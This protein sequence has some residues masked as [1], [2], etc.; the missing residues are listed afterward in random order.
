MN[1]KILLIDGSSF[2]FRAFYALPN[3]TAP[4]GFPTGVL[5]GVTNMLRQMLNKY[6]DEYQYW[7]CVFDTKGKT[8]REDI[9]PE[10]KANRRETPTELIQQLPLLYDMINYMGI[11][12]VMQEGV[13]ADDVIGSIATQYKQ[14]GYQT[15][16][17]TGDKDFAQLVNN[18]ITLI[19]TMT[20]EYLDHSGVIE[21][22]SVTPAQII[23]YLSLIGDTV[24]NVKG[25]DKCGPKTA[26]KWLTQY[27]DIDNLIVHADNISG[28]VGNNLRSSIEWL[29]MAR[30]LI[31]IKQDIDL[32]TLDLQ[33][34]DKLTRQ[35]ANHNKLEPLYAQ[36][37]FKTWLKQA[38]DII[39]QQ[40]II[41]SN[42]DLFTVVAELEQNIQSKHH[43][44][45][46]I[47]DNTQLEN[48][49][50][51][52]ITN[53]LSSSFML[54]EEKFEV[55]YDASILCILANNI[56]Y[57]YRLSTTSDLL[58]NSVP[59]F[60][61][62]IK[63]KIK[64]YLENNQIITYNLKKQLYLLNSLD[65]SITPK[66]IDDLQLINYVLDSQSSHT[67]SDIIQ[68][69]NTIE[70]VHEEEFFGKGAKTKI[71][72]DITEI[73]LANYIS[74][75]LGNFAN[76][77]TQIYQQLDSKEINLYQN[78]ELAIVNI[79]FKIEQSGIK[80]DR[81]VFFNLSKE[82]TTQIDKIVN[83]IYAQTNTLI[84]LNS[85]KQLQDLLFNQLKL[86]TKGIKKN[87]NGYST[88]E[89]S[90]NTLANQGIHIANL[91]LEYRNLTKLLNTYVDKLPK[92]VDHQDR[93]HT[94]FE[95]TLVTSGRLSSREPNLQNIPV[96]NT[97]GR[98]IR[99]GFVAQEGCQLIC[100][101]YSQI[102]LRILAHIT[103]EA[104][105]IQAFINN[106][107]IHA[108]TAS[109]IF[110]LPTE[111]ISS[112]QR[113]FAKTINFGL[114]YGQGSYGLAKQLNIEVKLAKEYID[115][116]FERYSNI[117]KFME[118]IKQTATKQ[119]YV[120]TIMGRKIYIPNINSSNAMLRNAAARLALNSPMQ[121]S[122]ADIIKIAMVNVDSFIQ[123]HKLTARMVLQ[124]HD[125]L[126]IEVPHNEVEMVKSNIARLMSDGIE[127]KVP[128]VIDVKSA[129]NWNDAH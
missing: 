67:L 18:D 88:D 120:S 104:N 97:L 57:I 129:L 31:T 27:N 114:M 6:Q 13:E 19:N 121:G 112:D 38:R 77:L 41:N 55:S 4:D 51:T 117:R 76:T 53:K 115:I 110:S 94:K 43:I 16:I 101:D 68:K 111:Q 71:T 102:E 48:V 30:F 93:L 108:I 79:L 89:E 20:N 58:R 95:Q 40:K 26:V 118:E 86:P 59:E 24:D 50:E 8:F 98:Q 119:G 66:H 23:D 34:I 10:Y 122:S 29:S 125:E 106:Q 25:V 49:L 103:D 33:D 74:V 128:L 1:K 44:K 100:A 78:I 15:L 105:L 82:I 113:R 99:S 2:V 73:E 3:L 39:A 37:N 36:Y 42:Q 60:N 83:E 70:I 54:I 63:D 28:V 9:Y 109:E 124:V 92:L 52:L 85:T 72:P 91:L 80:I 87:S 64:Q 81:T 69:H 126:I 46:Q 35:E 32:A 45:T 61:D 22:F 12:V 65:I 21:K 107:D 96:R 62:R 14:H 75:L 7:V 84:N 17:A 11:R 56:C 90:L 47:V 123:Q 5:Y 116:Y 127:L